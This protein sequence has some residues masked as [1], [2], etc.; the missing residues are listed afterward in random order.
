MWMRTI[1]L[2]LVYPEG[3]KKNMNYRF[4]HSAS[5]CQEMLCIG[6]MWELLYSEWAGGSDRKREFLTVKWLS[7]S[8]MHTWIL[9]FQEMNIFISASD[10]WKMR[11]D[12]KIER[13]RCHQCQKA[14]T[15]HT[16]LNYKL[17]H[18]FLLIPRRHEYVHSEVKKITYIQDSF[19]L[20]NYYLSDKFNFI[21]CFLFGY[22]KILQI[23]SY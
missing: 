13:S 17:S 12:M 14:A 5:A 15:F 4:I 7:L 6:I 1:K 23:H 21:F 11:V 20:T 3:K 19:K 18:V 8:Y 16:M 2:S 10:T 22:T 9:R